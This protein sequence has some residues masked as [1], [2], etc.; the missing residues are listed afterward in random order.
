MVPYD[1]RAWDGIQTWK[2]PKETWLT[3]YTNPIGH[4]V[5]KAAELALENP[6]GH[7]VTR[8]I[9]GLIDVV[10]DGA[11]WTVRTEAILAEFRKDGHAEVAQLG[12]IRRRLACRSTKRWD[13]WV[14]STNSWR[15]GRAPLRV[16][17][18]FQEFQVT[19]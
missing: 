18:V 16:H 17:S 10:N 9:Q 5:D 14:P 3:K 2:H 15:S 19:L 1:A 8:A 13:I 6:V 4:V 7:V 12:D 11:S